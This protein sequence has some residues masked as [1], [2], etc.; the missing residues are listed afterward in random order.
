MGKPLHYSE[1][2]PGV[3]VGIILLN[4][5]KTHVLLGKRKGSHGAGEYACPGGWVEHGEY[6]TD[7]AIREVLEE[8]GLIINSQDLK[9][10]THQE[11][12]TY[13]P[14]HVINFG[15]WY[16]FTTDVTPE[17]KEP[18]KCEGWECRNAKCVGQRITIN[19]SDHGW[20]SISRCKIF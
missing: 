2:H 13:L 16:H 7:C 3:G 18:D 6:L 8:T 4:P 11:S 1:T 15:Y 5:S 10:L 12:F 19:L 17:L 14:K 20:V 9:F